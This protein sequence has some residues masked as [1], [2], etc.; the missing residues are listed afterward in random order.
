MSETL[1][2]IPID[3]GL[4][5]KT[6]VISSAGCLFVASL[7]HVYICTYSWD[8]YKDS[9]ISI[10]C[11]SFYIHFTFKYCNSLSTLLLCNSSNKKYTSPCLLHQ[12]RRIDNWFIILQRLSRWRRRTA[13]SQTCSCSWRISYLDKFMNEWERSKQKESMDSPSCVWRRSQEQ[14]YFTLYN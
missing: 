13:S 11:L 1:H 2:K 10:F 3:T 12:R 4:R 14:K 6:S 9:F 5:N 8:Q 7:L